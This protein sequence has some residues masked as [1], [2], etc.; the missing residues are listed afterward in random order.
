VEW[1]QVAEGGT[2]VVVVVGVVVVA[3]LADV[4]AA[5]NVA[6]RGGA[7]VRDWGKP[8]KARSRAARPHHH[9]HDGHESRVLLEPGCTACV[10]SLDCLRA[11][12]RPRAHIASVLPLPAL[13]V[14]TQHI[15]DI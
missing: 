11:L 10:A 13:D 7:R 3:Q 1:G 4:A 9:H 2:V 5:Q 14:T 8:R 6:R 12:P 15:F